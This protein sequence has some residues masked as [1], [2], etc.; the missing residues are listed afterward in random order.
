MRIKRYK[1]FFLLILVFAF[2]SYAKIDE[3]LVRK[4]FPDFSS[5]KKFDVSDP[6]SDKPVNTSIY[7]VYSK[8]ERVGFVR[9]VET[10]TGCNSACL[11]I[12]YMSFY[13]K[14]GSY[15]KLVS[16]VGLTKIGHASFTDEDYAKLAFILALAP[17]RLS[18]IKNPRDLTDA[19]SGETLKEF[20]EIVVSGAAYSSL[21][22]HLYHQLTLQQISSKLLK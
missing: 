22:I 20:K 12:S 2:N 4:I 8:E 1:S 15:I 13:K 14:D 7:E 16:K 21:R 5:L 9:G 17:A 18:A 3:S 11:P 6:I 19:L 10:T